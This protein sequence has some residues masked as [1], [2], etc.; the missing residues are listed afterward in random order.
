MDEVILDGK[1]AAEEVRRLKELKIK[2]KDL[3]LL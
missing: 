3:M 2:S 1:K